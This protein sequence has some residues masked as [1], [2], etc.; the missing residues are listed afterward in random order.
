MTTR[1]K[2]WDLP[3]RV[4]HWLLV[5]A[6]GAAWDSGEIGGNWMV[7]HGR[8]GLLIVGLV[9]FRLVWGVI[10][11]T[12]ARFASFVRGPAS[13]L[14]YLRGQWHG[15]GHNPLGA[16]SVLGLL[17]LLALQATTGLFAYND[18]IG[19]GGPFYAAIS[20]DL[21]ATLTKIHHKLFDGLLVLVGLHIAAI[22][23][24]THVKKDNLVKPMLTG[25]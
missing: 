24:Y 11:S 23:F 13:I 3:T 2:L 9:A 10:G 12:Y 14:A 25:W 5:V 21:S 16:L 7:W 20:S 17:T 19:F 8:I 15:I 6:I 4:F 1:I 18:D 22:L